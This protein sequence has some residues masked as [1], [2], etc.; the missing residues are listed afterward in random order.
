MAARKE[1]GISIWEIFRRQN[2]NDLG[3]DWMIDWMMERVSTEIRIHLP[4][5]DNRKQE[6]TYSHQPWKV[7]GELEV[8][9]S[10]LFG[11][12]GRGRFPWTHGYLFKPSR[13][14]QP[15]RA[16]HGEKEPEQFGSGG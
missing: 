11:W 12:Q 6:A 3:I 10:V 5:S 13:W 8:K 9:Q 7:R 4:A 15:K 2:Q 14:D 16:T 1:R